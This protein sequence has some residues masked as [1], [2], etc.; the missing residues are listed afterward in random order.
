MKTQIVSTLIT[1]LIV[2]GYIASTANAD[3]NL[4]SFDSIPQVARSNSQPSQE[5]GQIQQKLE[6]WREL[7]SPGDRKF[8]FQGY[9]N[10]YVNSDELL[11]YDS[12]TPTGSDREIRGWN[13]YKTLWEKF[14]PIDFPNW[15]IIDL[16]VTRLEV[17]GDTAWSTL[18]FV[19]RGEKDGVPYTGGQH[20][21]HIWKKIDGQWRI[22]HEHLTTMSDRE[23]QTRL[24]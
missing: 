20:G 19:G 22:V 15:K 7:F 23:I 21:T 3:S 16:D 6:Q 10:L 1:T 9:E 2:T 11:V 8:S 17:V 24:K 12:Y 4:I 5:I 18:S 13:N 14:I